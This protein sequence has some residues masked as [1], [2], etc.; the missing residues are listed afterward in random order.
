MITFTNSILILFLVVSGSV[1][2]AGTL[3][4]TASSTHSSS[5]SCKNLYDG[6]SGTAWWT[7]DGE[8][9]HASVKIQFTGTVRLSEIDIQQGS[10]ARFKEMHIFFSNGQTKVIHLGDIEGEWNFFPIS[11][12]VQTSFVLLYATDYYLRERYLNTGS[13]GIR[14]MRFHGATLE[15]I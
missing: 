4:C 3:S 8:A 2:N 6:N 12:P 11:P 14:G 15:G 10:L 7:K 5:S 13:Y 1:F 9:F